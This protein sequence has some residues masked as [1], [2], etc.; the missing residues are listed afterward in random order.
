MKLGA[1]LHLVL[2]SRMN[3]AMSCLDGVHKENLARFEYMTVMLMKIHA[4][5]GMMCCQLVNNDTLESLLS[6]STDGNDQSRFAGC[7]SRGLF[8]LR[9]RYLTAF[10]E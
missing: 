1:H 5:W 9:D 7:H 2:M 4:C 6:P 10:S 8:R 3:G